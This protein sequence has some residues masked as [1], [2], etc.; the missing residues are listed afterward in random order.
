MFNKKSSIVEAGRKLFFKYGFRRV[1]I[2]EICK[3]AKVS[4]VTYYKY[5]PDKESLFKSLVDELYAVNMS[6]FKE[7]IQGN[8]SFESAAKEMFFF[9]MDTMCRTGDEFIKDLLSFEKDTALGKYFQDKNEESFLFMKKIYREAQRKCEIRP[10]IKIELILSYF[11]YMRGFFNDGNVLRL[12]KDRTRMYKEFFNLIFYG[13][14]NSP[15][16]RPIE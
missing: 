16:D 2:G 10:N 13:I 7:L 1:S 12:Y 6:K 4:R 3:E 5:F 11:E 15:G 9:K 14:I 8:A